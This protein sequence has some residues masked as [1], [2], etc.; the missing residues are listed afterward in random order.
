MARF[1]LLDTPR[2][3]VVPLTTLR[4]NRYRY[5]RDIKLASVEDNAHVP[6]VILIMEDTQTA[7]PFKDLDELKRFRAALDNVIEAVEVREFNLAGKQTFDLR[8]P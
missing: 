4:A 7:Y 5:C 1:E 6:H 2:P 8:V 3:V